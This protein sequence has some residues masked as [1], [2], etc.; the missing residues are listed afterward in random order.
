M[1]SNAYQ[2][3]RQKPVGDALNEAVDLVDAS[4][5]HQRRIRNLFSEL[6]TKHKTRE[7]MDSDEEEKV[8]PVVQ[9]VTGVAVACVGVVAS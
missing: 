8:H 5:A 4:V 2:K 7:E 9:V 6:E 1:R 3:H